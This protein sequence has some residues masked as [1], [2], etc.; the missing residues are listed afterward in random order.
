MKGTVLEMKKCPYM[1]LKSNV[2]IHI[3]QFDKVVC[4]STANHNYSITIETV[5][6]K[7][8]FSLSNPVA[9]MILDEYEGWVE[10]ISKGEH[11][12]CFNFNKVA[13]III[14]NLDHMATWEN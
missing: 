1:K 14:K 13:D 4:V 8:N 3:I 12:V 10:K 7:Y 9:A 2:D 11:A 5:A 6:N